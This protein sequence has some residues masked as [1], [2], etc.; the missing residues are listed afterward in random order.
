MNEP[1]RWLW[2]TMAVT[3]P[4]TNGQFLYSKGLIEAASRAGLS[5]E[6]VA[7]DRPEARHR[8]DATAGRW[9]VAA[10]KPRSRWSS[11]VSRLPH[12]ANRTNTHSMRRLL[13]EFLRSPDQWEAIVVDSLAAGWALRRIASRFERTARPALIY[14]AHNHETSLARRLAAIHPHPLKRQINWIDA[15]KVARLER[16]VSQHADLITAD[17]PDD[18]D[19]FR[20]QYPDKRIGWLPPLFL[21]EPIADRRIDD[22]V[23]RRVVML[24]SFDWLPKR[25]NLAEFLSAA[26][27]LFAARG[28]ELQIVGAADPAFLDGLRSQVRA[29]T[30]TGPVDD[31]RR[32]LAEARF[33]IAAERIGGGFKLKA[34]DYV[35]HRVP[36]AALSGTIP[37]MPVHDGES[38]IISADAAAL[39]RRIVEAIDDFEMLN[40]LHA[41]AYAACSR[42]FTVASVA[43]LFRSFVAVTQADAEPELKT[44]IALS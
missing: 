36:M 9:W 22:R 13:D 11:T 14:V 32:Y 31:V 21:G 41:R 20:D 35:F 25:R 44:S 37:G 39:A 34:L 10:D 12:V 19:L 27:P 5:L 23:P 2:L 40:G 7:L 18:C 26:D 42:L 33:G 6:I 1:R 17:S 24:G 15:L 8:A 30:F 3:D 43:R 28:I 29:T 16:H 38:A 4:P